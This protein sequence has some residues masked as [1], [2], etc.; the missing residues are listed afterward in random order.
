MSVKKTVSSSQENNDRFASYTMCTDLNA[1]IQWAVR[2]SWL[3][4]T[5]SLHSH[6]LFR[7]A[8][9]T[10]EVGQTD[11]VSDVRSGFI[12]G[13]VRARLQVSVCSGY[14]LFHNG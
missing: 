3:K 1:S 2:L 13:S 5:H 4:N 14:D 7:P 10:R 11:L 8:I 9:L 12:S 6:P